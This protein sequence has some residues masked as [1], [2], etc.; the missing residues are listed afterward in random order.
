MVLPALLALVL[1]VS[2]VQVIRL[3]ARSRREASFYETARR[4]YVQGPAGPEREEPA[5]GAAETESGAAGQDAAETEG[6]AAAPDAAEAP[7]AP[8]LQVDFPAL[9]A[10]GRDVRAWISV[11]GT[12]ISYPVVQ[13]TDNKTYERRDYTG[14]YAWSGSIFLD[15]R[16]EADFAGRSAILYGHNLQDGSMFS[17]LERFQEEAFLAEHPVFYIA[18]LDALRTYE[19]FAVLVTDAA[20]PAYTTEFADD[21]AYAAYLAALLEDAVLTAGDAPAAQDPIALLSTCTNRGRTE[22]LVAAGRLTDLAPS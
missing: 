9:Q 3:T 5:A 20:G 16:C 10:A 6:G 15:C 14:A 8:A 7:A 17:Q 19:I 12:G 11:P 13:G 1:A 18:T 21:A 2:A 22:R 4:A